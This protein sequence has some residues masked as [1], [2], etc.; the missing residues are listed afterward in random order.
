MTFDS[1]VVLGADKWA[2]KAKRRF[3]IFICTFA[4]QEDGLELLKAKHAV[5]SQVV[6]LDHFND[7]LLADFLAELLH[8]EDDVLLGNL[9]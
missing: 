4:I 9:P 1:R 5:T 3:L 8:G 7:L 2:V 6:L